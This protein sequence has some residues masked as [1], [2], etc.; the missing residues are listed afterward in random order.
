MEDYINPTLIAT[1][2]QNILS[3][4]SLDVVFPIAA[5]NLMILALRLSPSDFFSFFSPI[6]PLVSNKYHETLSRPDGQI[7][8]S[9][10]YLFELLVAL[11]FPLLSQ[12]P[13]YSQALIISPQ[14]RP[15]LFLNIPQN[16]TIKD[17]K[18]QESSLIRAFNT[19]YSET[20]PFTSSV[21]SQRIEEEFTRVHF[22]A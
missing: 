7:L 15:H 5:L 21:F 1:M 19:I 6:W 14:P 17:L 20:L 9:L 3:I 12:L 2:K 16:F 10:L 8:A 4:I 18:A 22:L 13:G 11:D